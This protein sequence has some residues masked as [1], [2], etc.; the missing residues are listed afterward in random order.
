VVGVS[1]LNDVT[2][3]AFNLM[4]FFFQPQVMEDLEKKLMA[5][6]GLFKNWFWLSVRISSVVHLLNILFA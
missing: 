6:L 4:N 1:A 3:F 5:L 2:Y